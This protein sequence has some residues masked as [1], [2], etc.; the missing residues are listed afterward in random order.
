MPI[1]FRLKS[2]TADLAKNITEEVD[3]IS[4]TV[5]SLSILTLEI[6][7]LIGISI[8]LLFIDFKISIIALLSFLLFGF[9]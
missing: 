8:Y 1:I 5:H 3:H 9:S 7:I 2:N 6:L 4:A